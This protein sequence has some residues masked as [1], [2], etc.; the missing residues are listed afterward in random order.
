M[1]SWSLKELH[2]RCRLEIDRHGV[3]MNESLGAV[4]GTLL[5]QRFSVYYNQHDNI[6]VEHRT[7]WESFSGG[8]HST[9]RCIYNEAR[10]VQDIGDR[11]FLLELVEILRGKQVLD[12]LADVR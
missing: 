7:T 4:K 8:E 5:D 10:G 6:I 12:D 2:K 9:W 11:R 3:P 1:S